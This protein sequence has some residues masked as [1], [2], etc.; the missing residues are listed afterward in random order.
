MSVSSGSKAPMANVSPS[1]PGWFYANVVTGLARLVRPTRARTRPAWC[2]VRRFALGIAIVAALLAIL[3]LF[4]DAS[5]FHGARGLPRWIIEAFDQVTDFGRSGWFLIPIGIL[6]LLIATLASP[7]LPRMSRAVLAMASVR[8]GF[9]FTA[10]AI[11]GVFTSVVKRIVARGRPYVGSEVDPFL[12]KLTVWR[13]D[14]ASM[15]S[16]HTTTAFAAAVA[17]GTLWPQLRPLMW[18][19]ACVIALSRIATTAHFPSDVVAG[20]I[21]GCVG[22]LLVRDWFAARGLG[23]AVHTNGSVFAKPGPSFARLKRLARRCLG[24]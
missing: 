16:G 24:R 22:A 8:L 20:A 18:T 7:A 6:L 15:P 14:F 19:Y 21:V 1:W 5:A 13:S 12:Y 2:T 9:L 10:I 11:P 4:A 17:F 3:M 23:F